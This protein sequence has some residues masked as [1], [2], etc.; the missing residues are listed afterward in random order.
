MNDLPKRSAKAVALV[1]TILFAWAI[2]YLTVGYWWH[3]RTV[4]GVIAEGATGALALEI[5]VNL[6]D[7]VFF[8]GAGALL[9]HVSGPPRTLSL[10]LIASA[11]AMFAKTLSRQYTF[12]EGLSVLDGGMLFVDLLSPILFAAGGALIA[13]AIHAHIHGTGQSPSET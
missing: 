11:I 9:F 3:Q 13:R 7:L 6:P 12:L 2:Y 5:L 8:F 1:L 10:P 4:A